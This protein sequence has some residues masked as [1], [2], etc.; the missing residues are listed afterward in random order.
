MALLAR[1]DPDWG[2]PSFFYR[3][4]MGSLN[5][6]EWEVVDFSTGDEAAAP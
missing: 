2:Y 6:I 3:H 5:D 4:T 1:F